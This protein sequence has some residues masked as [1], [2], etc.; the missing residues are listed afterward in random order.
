MLNRIHPERGTA[1]NERF[2]RVRAQDWALDHECEQGKILCEQR[3][4]EREERT[5]SPNRRVWEQLREYEQAFEREEQARRTY[6][7][8]YLAR[9]ER[10]EVIADREWE[11]LKRQ[12]REE[13]EAFFA[14]GKEIYKEL[15]NSIYQ[16]VREVARPAWAAYYEAQDYPKQTFDDRLDSKKDL[17]SWQKALVDERFAE[18]AAEL[19]QHRDQEYKL[20]LE[21]QK[22]ERHELTA[23]QEQGLGSYHL[24]DS[25]DKDHAPSVV[26]FKEAAKEVCE[27]APQESESFEAAPHITPAEN[28]RVREGLDMAGDV[29]MGLLSALG[30]IGDR[31][32]DGFFGG[33]APAN[34]NQQ[35]KPEPKREIPSGPDSPRE[36]AI[37]R[38]VEA[39]IR[40]AEADR[41][42]QQDHEYWR[43]RERS[44]GY[45][46]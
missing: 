39:A 20:L 3:L 41:E 38:A 28:P 34:Q 22:E 19:R 2:E 27:V 12:Q 26:E 31:L 6:D 11:L 32:F 43:E 16:D 46:D 1:L 23:R 14:E 13:R 7:P 5:P 24:L 21:R 35:P 37:A 29:G 33:P 8:G 36:Q 9:E 25:L 15:R 17:A 4:L 30:T 44:R 18:A 45:R 10:R 40:A 42:R